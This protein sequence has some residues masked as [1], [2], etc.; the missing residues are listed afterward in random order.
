MRRKILGLLFI[1]F[2]LFPFINSVS[3]CTI[4]TVTDVDS[5]FFCGNEDNSEAFQW[6][7]WFEPAKEDKYGRVFIGYRIGNSLDVPQAGINDQ[8]LAI[9]LNGVA[10]TPININPEREKYY[11][12]IFTKWLADCATIRE[13][14]ETLSIYNVI[15]LETNPNQIHV[16]DKTGDAIVL[17][18]DS[19]GELNPTNISNGYLVSTNFNLNNEE[20]LSWELNHSGRYNTTAS[21]IERMLQ[22]NNLSVEGCRDI[23]EEVALNPNL[24]YGF[25]ADLKQG[26]IYLYSHDDFERT[27]VLDIHEELAKGTHSYAIETLVTQQTGIIG[28]YIRTSLILSFFITIIVFGLITGIFY[29]NLSPKLQSLPIKTDSNG[30]LHKTLISRLKKLQVRSRFIIACIISVISFLFIKTLIKVGPFFINFDWT[31]ILYIYFIIVP[32]LIIGTNFRPSIAVILSSLGVIFNELFTCY[33]N[34][35][36]GELWIQ[37]ILS[38]SSLV[39]TSF[40]I[41]LVRIKNT[42]LALL[43]GGLWYLIGFYLPAFLYY[44]VMFY[45]TPIGLFAYSIVQVLIYII[46]IPLVLLFNRSVQ[47]FTQKQDLEDLLFL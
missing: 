1:L 7:I 34:G 24:G 19:N 21:K 37:L 18:V 46:L 20:Q 42:K 44:C 30:H 31:S 47:Y 25:V 4:F 32:V 12:A 14:K 9:D 45:F 23:L 27:A 43:L 36:G 26:V 38:L 17:A 28:P 39:G 41:A 15:D 29:F 5:L 40:I 13:V 10:Y 6:R 16:A 33:L 35:Y 8:G 22:N 3:G 11:G 2:C